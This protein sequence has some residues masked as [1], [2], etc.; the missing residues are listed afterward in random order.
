MNFR[1]LSD[2]E[3]ADFAAN[4]LT[5]LGGTQLK[6]I[7]STLRTRLVSS[8]GTLPTDLSTKSATAG[9][10]EAGRMAAVSAKNSTREQVIAGMSQVKNALLVSL[11]S[12]DQ[13]DLCGFDFREPVIGP[14]VPQPPTDLSAFGYSN[15]VNVTKFKG[16]NRS[17]SVVY[18]IWRRQGDTG[19]WGLLATTKKQS[20]TDAPV[21]PGQFYEYRARATAARSVSHYSN[22]AVVYGAA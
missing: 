18:E 12:K 20:F 1:R 14:Y 7:D 6:S 10:A 2:K 3:L 5:L 15:G 16:N 8:L 4:V 9:V 13:Y 19:A 11:A 21:T 17:G 22:S